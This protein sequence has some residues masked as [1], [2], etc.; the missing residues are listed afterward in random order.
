MSSRTDL[1]TPDDTLAYAQEITRYHACDDV[2]VESIARIR[3]A[4][5]VLVMTLYEECP[6][7]DDRDS[8]IKDARR[9]M[10]MANAA[11]ALKGRI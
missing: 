3:D 2:Q 9:C 7:C 10:M 11:V 1:W 8:A 5:A 4:V 6:P